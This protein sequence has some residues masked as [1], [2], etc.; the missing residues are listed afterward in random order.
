MGIIPELS[1]GIR[2]GGATFIA[3]FTHQVVTG[4]CSMHQHADFEIV[5][6]RRG[7]GRSRLADGSAVAFSKDDVVVYAP[8]QA[9]D[10]TQDTVGTDACIHI[11]YAGVLPRAMPGWFLISSVTDPWMHRELRDLSNLLP[12]S[13]GNE[14]LSLDLRASALLV[15]LLAQSESAGPPMPGRSTSAAHAEKADRFLAERFRD[16]GRLEEV[17]IHVGVGYDHL[18]H[19]YRQQFGRSMVRRLIDLRIA[20]AK[21]LLA[22]A[23]IPIAAVAAEVG[24]ATARHFSTIFREVTG[25]SPAAF[26]EDE[27]R[28]SVVT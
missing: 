20:H 19:A 14:R 15:G 17:A 25:Y 13:H 22:H 6:H 18:R 12:T 26:R 28:R 4:V 23:P 1:A 2:V 7:R 21:I 16:L 3:G 9:H 5:H 10:Q 8:R 27:R 24:Y 11:G